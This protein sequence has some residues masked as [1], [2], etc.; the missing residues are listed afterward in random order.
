MEKRRK[1]DGRKIKGV[2]VR[3]TNN[4]ISIADISKEKSNKNTVEAT[5]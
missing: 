1:R 3:G 5:K 4:K 2:R